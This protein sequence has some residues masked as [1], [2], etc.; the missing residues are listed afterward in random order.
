M[1]QFL[2]GTVHEGGEEKGYPIPVITG[3]GVYSE[4]SSEQSQ[5]SV[6][7]TSSG[8]DNATQPVFED[9][10]HT[11]LGNNMYMTLMRF[12]GKI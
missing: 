11:H 9:I 4:R 6:Q 12:K 3:M 10:H 1:C 2:A 8:H 7:Q 5:A